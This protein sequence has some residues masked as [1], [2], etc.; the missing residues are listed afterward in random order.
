M[1]LYKNYIIFILLLSTQVYSQIVIKG[2]VKDSLQNPLKYTNIIAKPMKS[3]K[4]MV[5]AI[6]DDYGFYKLKLKKNTR[7]S[8]TVSFMGFQ[9]ETLNIIPTKNSEKNFILKEN[10]NQLDEVVI[11]VPITIK[12][13]TILYK[14]NH[15]TNG[16]ERKLKNILKKLPGIEVS[17]NGK[18]TVQGKEVKKIL[19]DGKLFFGGGTK[20][21]IENI[22]ANA[23]KNIQAI[24]N[25]NEVGF[26]K[27]VFDSDEMVINIEL[28]KDKKRFVFG[29]IE[30]GKGNEDYYKSHSNLFYYS[31]KTSVN[32][33]GD[34]NNIGEKTFT[35]KNYF[36]FNGGVNVI[37][38]ENFNFKGNDFSQFLESDNI[39][40]S[41]RQFGALNITKTNSSKLEVSGYAIFSK[42]KSNGIEISRDEYVNFIENKQTITDLTNILGTG[43]FNLDYTPNANE[44]WYFKTQLKHIENDKKNQISS[45]ILPTINEIN[46]K[47]NGT[48]F[49]VNQNIEWHNDFSNKHIFSAVADYTYEKTNPQI[50]WETNHSILQNLIPIIPG[51]PLS[52][53]QKKELEQ[54]SFSILFKDFWMLNQNNHLYSTIGNSYKEHS[55]STKA[56]QILSNSEVVFPNFKNHFS[57]NLHDF[58]IG[59]HYKF[60]TGIFTFNQGAYLHRYHWELLN[61]SKQKWTIL[62]DF[63]IDIKFS[64]SKKIQ[65]NY[66]LKT[67]FLDVSKYANGFVLNSYNS[68]F[69]GNEKLENELYYTARASYRRFSMFRGLTLTLNAN[70]TKKI[71]GFR[72]AVKFDGVNQ[73]LTYVLLDNPSENLDFNGRIKKR[74]KKVRGSLSVNYKN[75]RFKQ[76]IDNQYVKNKNNSYSYRASVETL[77]DKLPNIEI[78]FKQNF[79]EYSSRGFESKFVTNELFVTI[80][81]EFLKNFQFNFDYSKY[82]YQQKTLG[83]EN[84]YELANA[85]L[86]YHKENSVWTFKLY[87][88]NLLDATYKQNNSFSDY[89]ISDTKTYILPRVLLFSVGYN[90]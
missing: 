50:F 77:L 19:I 5:F 58:F 3:T 12:K 29:D 6:T 81:Y 71:K 28:K 89:L 82:I 47:K 31:P 51:N 87:G 69:K 60:R 32:F 13:D 14:I 52:L 55:F 59:L 44:Q 36:D 79:G 67:N 9:T 74:I 72:N 56:A 15:F 57:Y 84:N 49:F 53:L 27:K 64:K 23:V 11:K 73:F 16:K 41:K 42:N 7:Y 37:F 26:L 75:S 34:I 39:F 25:Y 20:L 90:L 18:V 22:P 33:I 10:E 48:K 54:H 76:K 78:G 68:V 43:K 21:G 66:A 8:L 2:F 4:D 46:T 45:Q 62:P 85:S 30:G 40:K 80:E 17:K 35:L 38:K 86:S 70:Y 65:L 88:N 61:E 83:Q 24:D 1:V 63:K